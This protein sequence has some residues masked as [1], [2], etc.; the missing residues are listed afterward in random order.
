M[1]LGLL[2]CLGVVFPLGVVGLPLI[3]GV[4]EHPG[5]DLPLGVVGLAVE[6]AL[7]VCSGLLLR[8][9]GVTSVSNSMYSQRRCIMVRL[10]S[11]LQF[12]KKINTNRFK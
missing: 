10:V 4:L 2:E 12:I 6:F 3:L 7:K 5:I 11:C 8:Q 9:E 1:I